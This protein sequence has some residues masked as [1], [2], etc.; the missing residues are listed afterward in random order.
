METS[1]LSGSSLDWAVAQ[2]SRMPLTGLRGGKCWYGPCAPGGQ[3]NPS[4][5]W[6]LA[7]PII[8]RHLISLS[9]P[10]VTT[11]GE[12]VETWGA[13]ISDYAGQIGPTPLIAA[14]RCFVAAKLGGNVEVPEGLI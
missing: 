3:W 1:E 8:H 7:G 5:N 13:T 12:R 14:M 6:D 11:D 2:A 10:F 9:A 4:T